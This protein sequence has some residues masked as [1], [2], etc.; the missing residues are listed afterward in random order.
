MTPQEQRERR[1]RAA[2]RVLPAVCRQL[3]ISRRELLGRLEGCERE[4]SEAFHAAVDADL[5]RQHD[6]GHELTP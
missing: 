6:D 4:A 5:A 2:L 1:Q 3:G